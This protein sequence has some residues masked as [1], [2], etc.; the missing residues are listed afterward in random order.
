MGFTLPACIGVALARE[1]DVIGISGDGSLPFNVQ[2]LQ[3][4]VHHNLPVK[5]FVWNNDAYLSIR[6][7]Q[8][9]FFEGRH[10]GTTPKS[11]V[12]L[13]SVEKIA[14]S[15]GIPYLYADLSNLDE[16]IKNTINYDGPV[17]CEVMCKIKQ[18]VI[19][20]LMGKL[21]EDGSMTPKPLEDL[22]PFLSR[23]EL[24]SNMIVEPLKE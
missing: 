7:T 24:H 6:N 10:I 14:H 11:G 17:I 2:E 22:Y 4:I 3:T 21:N 16:S 20:T 8:D 23:E 19:P 12:S 9:R 1:G 15:Y 5:L 18:E 13:P